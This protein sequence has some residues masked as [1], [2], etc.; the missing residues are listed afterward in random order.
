MC[1]SICYDGGRQDNEKDESA[2]NR[3]FD[4]HGNHSFIYSDFL[5]VPFSFQHTL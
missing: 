5:I 3:F 1:T 4:H 2:N